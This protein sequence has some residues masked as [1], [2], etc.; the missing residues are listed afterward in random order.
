M[1]HFTDPEFWR[2]YNQLPDQ[3][4]ELA[5][6]NYELLIA[7]PDH[8]SL[9]FKKVRGRDGLWSVRVGRDYRA[10][11]VEVADGLQWF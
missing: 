9:H 3:I 7:N 6:R 2:L 10:L 1:P 8:P 11:A 4:R 5:D